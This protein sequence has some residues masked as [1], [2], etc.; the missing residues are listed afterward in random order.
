MRNPG[1][2]TV[3]VSTMETNPGTD[4]VIVAIPNVSSGA[5]M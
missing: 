3:T 4:A 2:T 5:E 1:V